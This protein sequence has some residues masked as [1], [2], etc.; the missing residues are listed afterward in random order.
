MTL[1]FQ[2]PGPRISPPE[3]N[4]LL[5]IAAIALDREIKNH[6]KSTASA[7][8]EFTYSLDQGVEVWI[9]KVFRPPRGYMTYGQLRTVILGLQLY[10]VLGNRPQAVTFRVLDGADSQLLGHGAVG[11]FVSFVSCS[12][13][14]GL[15]LYPQFRD[16][17]QRCS[18]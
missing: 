11:N 15:Q 6:G 16:V 3:V 10:I 8:E 1:E 17:L 18:L 9:L 13:S 14:D 12:L 5:L 7:R 4:A 2:N